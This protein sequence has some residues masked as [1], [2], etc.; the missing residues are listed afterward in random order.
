MVSPAQ[1]AVLSFVFIISLALVAGAPGASNTGHGTSKKWTCYME[2]LVVQYYTIN[3]TSEPVTA[4][5]W[6]CYYKSG[7]H[8]ST[9]LDINYYYIYQSGTTTVYQWLGEEYYVNGT[10]VKDTFPYNN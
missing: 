10:L 6:Y 9:T 5:P 7:T 8:T 3:G 4:Y 2:Q 1:I